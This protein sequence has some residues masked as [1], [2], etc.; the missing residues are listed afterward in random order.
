[1]N[2][3]WNTA[4]IVPDTDLPRLPVDGDSDFIHVGVVLLVV[5]RID[6]D[7]VEDFVQTG[8][9]GDFTV[10]HRFGR[11]VKHPHLRRGGLSG[12][13]IRIWTFDNVF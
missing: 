4:T 13:N 2:L 9:V 10:L 5:G 7:F 8:D 11:R 12:A 1:M 6:D 3:D